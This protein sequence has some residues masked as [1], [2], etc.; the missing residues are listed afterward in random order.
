MNYELAKKLKDAGFP[1][2]DVNIG[3]GQWMAGD[4][5]QDGAYGPTLSELMKACGEEF[6]ELEKRGD[7]YFAFGSSKNS[8]NMKIKPFLGGGS[9]S[10][11]A[12]AKLWLKLYK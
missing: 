11:E 2:P 4:I 1:Q 6:D 9:T 12:V 8:A 3:R 7:T 10:E 5:G